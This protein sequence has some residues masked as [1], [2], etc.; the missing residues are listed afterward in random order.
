MTK[1]VTDEDLEKLRVHLEENTAGGKMARELYDLRMEMLEV[2]NILFDASAAAGDINHHIAFHREE[3]PIIAKD[4]AAHILKALTITNQ[5][6]HAWMDD[7]SP[8]DPVLQKAKAL[9]K[10]IREALAAG[11]KHY[12]QDGELLRTPEEIL[13]CIKE[14]GKVEIRTNALST[15]YGFQE[16]SSGN[17]V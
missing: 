11:T 8:E 13:E 10:A 3:V 9:I 7:F 1:F 4:M 15:D 12:N 16:T 2:H 6:V 17:D 14:E 5:R